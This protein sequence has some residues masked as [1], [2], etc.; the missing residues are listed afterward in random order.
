MH[1]F[2]LMEATIH[3]HGDIGQSE[4]NPDGVTLANVISQVKKQA[5]ATSLLVEINSP[6]GNLQTGFDIFNYLKSTGLPIKTVGKGMVASVAT[7]IFMAGTTRVL[8][9]GTIFMVHLPTLP[10][11]NG[12]NADYVAQ[13]GKE[14]QEVENRV[15]K[16]YS[17]H[18]SLDKETLKNLMKND[19]FLS[20]Q[21]VFSLGFTTA[22]EPLQAVA[23]L[24]LESKKPQNKKNM[25]NPKKAQSLA[26]KI[27][28]M[29][30]DFVETIGGAQMKIVYTA[31]QQEINFP[32]LADDA[33]IEVG[34]MATID[35]QPADGT[36]T[37]ADG[38]TMEFEAG[39]LKVYTLASTEE[40]EEQ[41]LEEMQ[42][43][44]DKANQSIKNLTEELAQAKAGTKDLKETNKTLAKEVEQARTMV[45]QVQKLQSELQ[46]EIQGTAPTGGKTG[47]PTKKGTAA[48]AA[49]AAYRAK[50]QA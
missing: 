13:L 47:K 50:R 19:T 37:D 2:G 22:E 20:E 16:F 46:A 4:E 10:Q 29:I 49:M 28:K 33:A 26:A 8:Q 21:E 7:V 6:G 23:V 31:D 35:G 14:M 42:K 40:E 48:K 30:T 34:A 45:M 38:N 43:K 25:K 27:S 24:T 9:Q 18:L 36:F 11:I 1:I 39:E 3:I 41:A 17:Q 12:G 5:N 44:L 15:L 32:D